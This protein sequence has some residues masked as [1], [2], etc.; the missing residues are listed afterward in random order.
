MTVDQLCELPLVNR[1][2][3]DAALFLWVPGPLLAIGAHIPLMQAWGFK[4]CAMAFTWVKLRPLADPS[5]F[6]LSDLHTGCGFTTRKNCEVVV[7]GKRGRSL[8]RDAGVHEVIV[9]PRRQHSRKPDELHRRIERYVG[10]VGPFL[11]LFARE[12]RPGWTAGAMNSSYS[13]RL[14][15]R[16]CL[17]GPRYECAAK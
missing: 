4:P 15:C 8:R 11:E 14:M 3:Q 13:I 7:L 2:A 10:N 17:I 9:A 6:K 5:N 12:T 16:R 1:I